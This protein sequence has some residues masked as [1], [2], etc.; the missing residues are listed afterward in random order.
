MD[1]LRA[2]R[3][4]PR[5]RHIRVRRGGKG[6]MREEAQS[7]KR[8]I[9]GERRSLVYAVSSGGKVLAAV[10]DAVPVSCGLYGK[11]ARRIVR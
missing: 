3:F 9:G 2:A 8:P 1:L 11:G 5:R 6:G 10:P 7:R 4:G